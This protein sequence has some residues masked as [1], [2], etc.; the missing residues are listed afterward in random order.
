M[1]EETPRKATRPARRRKGGSPSAPRPAIAGT[2]TRRPKP[3]AKPA[4][5]VSEPAA[6]QTEF[7][8]VARYDGFP[9]DL[10]RLASENPRGAIAGALLLGIGA[11]VLIGIWISSA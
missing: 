2:R 4:A 5:A 11:G 9:T 1:E 8:E 3:S 6:R 7:D 10:T